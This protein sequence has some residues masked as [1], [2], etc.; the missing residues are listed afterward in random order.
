MRPLFHLMLLAALSASACS[1]DGGPTPD[2]Q[3]VDLAPVADTG[4]DVLLADALLADAGPWPD[5]GFV[6][7]PPAQAGEL[8]ALSISTG[9]R[10]LSMC[11]YRGEVILVANIA[12]N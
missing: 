4:R 11:E 2:V 6:C 9:I 10:E 3:D 8:Y 5:V 1:D 7:Q 12:A